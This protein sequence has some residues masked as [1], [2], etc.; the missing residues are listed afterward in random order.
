MFITFCLL[1][2]RWISCYSLYRNST[3][4]SFCLVFT[5]T[6]IYFFWLWLTNLWF[7]M[8]IKKSFNTRVSQICTFLSNLKIYVYHNFFPLFRIKVLQKTKFWKILCIFWPGLTR[9]KFYYITHLCE[10]EL[11]RKSDFFQIFHYKTI[12]IFQKSQFHIKN[13]FFWGT[14]CWCSSKIIRI[15]GGPI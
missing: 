3:S 11:L 9:P 14:I 7:S 6:H 8:C 1:F 5:W 15:A 2:Q 10:I 4:F 13:V 12:N